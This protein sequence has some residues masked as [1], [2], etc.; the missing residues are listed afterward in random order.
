MKAGG[1]AF[2]IALVLG[3]A[4]GCLAQEASL[5]FSAGGFFAGEKAYRDIYGVGVPITAELWIKAKGP[6]GLAA[7]YSWLNGS[8]HA[9]PLEDGDADYPVEFRRWTIPLVA[10]YQIDLKAIRIRAGA[11]IGIHRY[12]EVWPTSSPV[13]E[14]RKVSPRIMASVS[15]KLIGKLS[16]TGTL[17]YETIPTGAGSLLTNEINLGG[18]QVLGGL[19]YRI[20]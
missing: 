12:E 20:F 7:G 10:F 8:G 6:I 19:S 2:G 4:A 1:L 16:L 17:I 9:V 14:G 3:L 11:G 5:S 13:F 15:M 18:F